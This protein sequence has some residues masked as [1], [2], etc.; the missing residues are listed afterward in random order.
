MPTLSLTSLVDVVSKSG[1]PKAT[2]VRDIKA[3]LAVPYDPATD[4]YRGIREAI[5]EAHQLGLGK[6]HITAVAAGTYGNRAAAYAT[7]AADY[8]GWWGR[9][10]ITWLAPPLGVWGPAGSA[11]DVTINP[12]LGLEINGASHAINLYFKKR[13]AREKPRRYHHASY[14]SR[15]LACE[16]SDGIFRCWMFEEGICTPSCRQRGSTLC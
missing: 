8:I 5:I 14:A 7:L 1:T 16:S 11:F 10:A 15:V 13:R 4:Y 9:K 3:Q 12:E 6:R 2:C